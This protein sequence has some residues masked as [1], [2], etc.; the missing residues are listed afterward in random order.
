MRLVQLVFLVAVIGLVMAVFRDPVGRVA[1]IVFTTGLGMFVFGLLGVM[2]LF[3]TIG[4]FGEADT[5]V[6]HI[7]AVAATSVVL[8]MASTAMAGWLFVGAWLVVKLV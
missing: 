2:A 5:F 6:A 4:A 8:A 7:E 3:Q 1:V